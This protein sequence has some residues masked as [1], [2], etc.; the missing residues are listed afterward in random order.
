[1]LER[2][3]TIE[4]VSK[5]I[6]FSFGIGKHLLWKRQNRAARYLWAQIIESFKGSKDSQKCI[7]LPR[8][9]NIIKHIMTLGKYTKNKH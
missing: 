4:Q 7:S 5:N 6:T 1:M 2:G 3:F 9:L 8:P